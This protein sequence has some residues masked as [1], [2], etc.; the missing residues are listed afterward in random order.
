MQQQQ[1]NAENGSL[2]EGFL[3]ELLAGA[4]CRNK[5]KG[6]ITR[7]GRFCFGMPPRQ[8]L[9]RRMPDSQEEAQD[10][11]S[12]DE[13]PRSSERPGGHS[14]F[15]IART[16]PYELKACEA[17]KL[18]AEQW[19]CPVCLDLCHNPVVLDGCSH[20]VCFS[21]TER[22]P[23]GDSADGG[24]EQSEGRSAERK[25]LFRCP[26]CRGKVY[27]FRS[28]RENIV[29]WRMYSLVKIV[30]PCACPWTGA[31]VD[32]EKHLADCPNN[33]S[34]TL[35]SSKRHRSG[36][37]EN[38]VASRSDSAEA[39]APTP[40]AAAASA[41]ETS[42]STSARTTV[43]TDGH[44]TVSSM[45]SSKLLHCRVRRGRDWMWADQDIFSGNSGWIVRV[46]AGGWVTVV[47]D[48]AAAGGSTKL[49]MNNYRMGAEGGMFDLNVCGVSQPLGPD[50]D[51]LQ[52]TLTLY[53]EGKL[54]GCSVVRHAASWKW[55]D[56]DR[57][58][59]GT[60]SAP[61]LAS[62]ARGIVLRSPMERRGWVSVIWSHGYI[63][64]YRVVDEKNCDI[65]V[66]AVN[67]DHVATR[68]QAES[69]ASSRVPAD[70]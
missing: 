7:G 23:K 65:E 58:I 41:V 25:L 45:D 50:V 27:G 29:A 67:A 2:R 54:A 39:P 24:E 64:E 6:T 40:P 17:E 70:M 55:D 47:W 68:S 5:N 66:V 59:G 62:D 11:S 15:D 18:L 52:R 56:Q 22:V 14:R 35:H 32:L 43:D 38:S 60:E 9:P 61:S 37:T 53:K 30:C 16:Q 69:E 48:N 28:L 42:T 31:I 1:A 57:R 3:Q 49:T 63:N 26:V 13:L 36:G 19:I 44:P 33:D 12:N 4:S 20:F 10:N 51:P 46:L 34:T 21:C 8:V